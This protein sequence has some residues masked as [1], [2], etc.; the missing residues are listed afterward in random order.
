MSEWHRLVQTMVEEI[1][2][3]IK[4]CNDE[5]LTLSSL[6]KRKIRVLSKKWKRR[7]K[8]STTANLV[9]ASIL[10]KAGC[11]IFIMTRNGFGSISDR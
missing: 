1:D 11:F 10:R 4:K 8:I 9:I 2:E 7:W 3:C 6:F 5:P